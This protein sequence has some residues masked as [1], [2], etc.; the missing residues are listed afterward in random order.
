MAFRWICL[1]MWDLW[2]ILLLV[3][4]NISFVY[5]FHLISFDYDIFSQDWKCF[6]YSFTADFMKRSEKKKK[7]KKN[8]DLLFVI[9]MQVSSHSGYIIYESAVSWNVQSSDLA[10]K[11]NQCRWKWRRRRRR[12]RVR[13]IK[14]VA[15]TFDSLSDSSACCYSSMFALYVSSIFPHFV[16][17]ERIC[18]DTRTHI[19]RQSIVLYQF[20]CEFTHFKESNRIIK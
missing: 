8:F 4:M 20:I 2:K 6:F 15:F 5:H 10:M 3:M 12:R 9:A 19:V 13:D 18:C 1:R 17:S 16:N 14:Y 7:R 11:Q